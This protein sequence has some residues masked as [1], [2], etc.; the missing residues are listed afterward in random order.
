MSRC[1]STSKRFVA[2]GMAGV[3]AVRGDIEVTGDSAA[4]AQLGFQRSR[5]L[6]A[7]ENMRLTI[8]EPAT[9]DGSKTF[10]DLRSGSEVWPLFGA[11]AGT[12]S[13]GKTETSISSS[14][15]A[16]A[17]APDRCVSTETQRPQRPDANEAERLQGRAASKDAKRSYVGLARHTAT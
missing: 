4:F 2:R 8:D 1:E 7:L 9:V 17:V 10:R 13:R 11:E 15:P 3:A 16:F 6:F 5:T 12:A 14:S